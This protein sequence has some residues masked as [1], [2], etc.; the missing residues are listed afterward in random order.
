MYIYLAR[1][2]APFCSIWL[3][4]PSTF[5]KKSSLPS[6]WVEGINLSSFLF[7]LIE[8]VYFNQIREDSEVCILSMLQVVSYFS[9]NLEGLGSVFEQ[10]SPFEIKINYRT[11]F[12]IEA[13]WLNGFGKQTPDIL[14]WELCP[15]YISIQLQ[16]QL[17]NQ[18][19]LTTL[20]DNLWAQQDLMSSLDHHNK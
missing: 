13:K 6:T 8:E 10:S 7:N 14:E 3:R 11:V 20:V 4:K 18:D 17:W 12:L 16:A 9:G 2:C 5:Y 19:M 1:T 15:W